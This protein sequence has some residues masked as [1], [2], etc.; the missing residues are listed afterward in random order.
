MW[1]YAIGGFVFGVFGGPVIIYGLGTLIV[2]YREH[3]VRKTIEMMVKEHNQNIRNIRKKYEKA[4]N[5][6]NA[7]SIKIQKT[8]AKAKRNKNGN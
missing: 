3:K 2:I 5:R 7:L 4:Q 1:Q 6:F 8:I